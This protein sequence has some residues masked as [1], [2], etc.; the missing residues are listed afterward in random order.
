[1]TGVTGASPQQSDIHIRIGILVNGKTIRRWE[2]DILEFIDQLPNASV[3]AVFENSAKARSPRSWKRLPWLVTNRLESIVS[4]RL[5]GKTW[6][7]IG[8]RPDDS[9]SFDD[10]AQGATWR[11]VQPVCSPS[12]LVHKFSNEDLQYAKS[13]RLDL[14]LRFGF[15]IIR[16]EILSV[17]RLGIW[18]FHHADNR[19]NR[20]GPP[21][22]WEFFE[23]LPT[24]G[25]TLQALTDDLD[26]GEVISRSHYPTMRFSWNENRRRLLQAAKFLMIDALTRVCRDPLAPPP[27]ESTDAPLGLYSGPLYLPPSPLKSVGAL[28]KVFGRVVSELLRRR[29]VRDQWRLAYGT[30]KPEGMSLRRLQSLRPP[31]DRFW[32][33]PFLVKRGDS[34]YVFFEDYGFED[35]IGKIAC[36]RLE[37]GNLVEVRTVIESSVHMSYPFVFSVSD[38]LWM[39]PESHGENS[40][41]LYRCVSFPYAWKKH[42]TLMADVSAADTTL[43]YDG[44]R[45][46]MFTNID[47]TGMRDH[48][49]ELHL[50]W[51]ED[52]IEGDWKPHRQNPVVRGCST[53]RMAGRLFVDDKGNLVRCS[54]RRGH[55]YGEAL[56][57]SII[58]RLSPDAY[59]ETLREIIEPSWSP[60]VTGVHHCDVSPEMMFAD[61]RYSVW[62]TPW[63]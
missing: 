41:D 50:F 14:A 5:Y 58:D 6:D 23:D 52:P 34:N 54:Q 56:Q 57:F 35:N 44:D 25:A 24:T 7:R 8:S 43:H 26:G 63:S 37:K 11:E 53:A 39:I 48:S 45:W 21:G 18:S 40:I 1:M 13:Q 30:G 20:G 49:A 27:A 29:T 9:T 51:T 33:D 22:F 62:R 19:V 55:L 36:G 28:F 42:K 16:G 4:K 12:G 61:V 38:S 46:W 17:P 47:R 10:L 3:V 59:N 60:A 15:N 2:R 31:K 32:A